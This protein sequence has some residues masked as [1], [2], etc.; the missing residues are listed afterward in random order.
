MNI[1]TVRMNPN[2]ASALKPEV[3]SE[4]VAVAAVTMQNTTLSP[5]VSKVRNTASFSVPPLAHLIVVV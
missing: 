5:V 2:S 4:A 3:A 1:P